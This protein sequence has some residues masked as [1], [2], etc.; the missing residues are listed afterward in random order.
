M[1]LRT[2]VA[3]ACTGLLLT[4]CKQTN[5]TSTAGTEIAAVGKTETASFTIEGMSCAVGCA[6]TLQKK[7]AATEGVTKATVDFDKK[8]A[9]VEY[10]S[11]VTS[12][13]KLVAVVEKAAGGDTYKV[14]NLKSS[15]DK[16]M[17]IGKDKDKK[18]KKKAK[19]GTATQEPVEKAGCDDAKMPKTGGCCAGKKACAS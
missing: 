5:A 16:A 1:K 6:N 19:K 8:L 12:P 4:A 17:M 15:A 2:F 9:T 10:D 3:V 13:E 18:K 7:L 11:A 14:V